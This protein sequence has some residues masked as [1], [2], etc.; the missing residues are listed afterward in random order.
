MWN[1]EKDIILKA[2]KIKKFFFL[3]L[4]TQIKKLNIKLY[5]S[6]CSLNIFFAFKIGQI[7]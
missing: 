7:N 2:M 6:I 4:Q 3:K 1:T 5:L